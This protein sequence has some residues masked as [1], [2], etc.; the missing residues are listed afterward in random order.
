VRIPTS[1]LLAIDV[2]LKVALIALLALAVTRP[3]LPQFAGKAMGGRALTY[4]LAALLVPAVWLATGRRRG[5]AYPWAIDILLVAPFLID[6]VGNALDLYDTVDW[7][8]DANHFVNWALLVGSFTAFLRYTDVG[9][10]VSAGLTIGFGAVTAIVW[11]LAEYETFIKDSPE[12]VTAYRDTLGDLA[13]GLL[14]SVLAAM[15]A[16]SVFWHEAPVRD[17]P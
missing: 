15:L 8:D 3:D 10:L 6:T 1:V 5:I 4:P 7:W 16:V 12:L 17:H 9:R 11:E 14:G 13:L 2:A